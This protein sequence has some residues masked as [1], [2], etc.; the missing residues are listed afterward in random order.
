MLALSDALN[1]ATTTATS[2]AGTDLLTA[3]QVATKRAFTNPQLV[4]FSFTSC[5]VLYHATHTFLQCISSGTCVFIIRMCDVKH[6][7]SSTFLTSFFLYLSDLDECAFEEFCDHNCKNMD[8]VATNTT[9]VCSCAP[10]YEQQDTL[11]YAINGLS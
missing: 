6:Y 4:F 11:C 2:A 8:L 10:G 5:T 1:Q 3:C 9:H 7:V